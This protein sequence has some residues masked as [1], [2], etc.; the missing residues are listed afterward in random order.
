[1]N[2]DFL[3]SNR[4]WAIVIGAV[5]LYAQTKGWIGEPEMILIGTIMA[6]HVA[7]RTVD[8]FAEK[9]GSEDTK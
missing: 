4:F 3:K 9:A 2:F 7:V 5:A 1:M 6:G 8:R